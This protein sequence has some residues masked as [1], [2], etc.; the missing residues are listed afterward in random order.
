[1]AI[2]K[3]QPGQSV[4]FKASGSIT[5]GQLVTVSGDR[6]VTA[7]TAA[8]GAKAIGSAATAAANG[9]DVLVLIGGV[10]LLEAAS[11]ITAGALVVGAD[12]G[13]IAA[14]A[15]VTTPTPADVTSTRAILGI[16]LTSVD[17]S[18]A[19]D[20]RIEVLLFR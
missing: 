12:G 11:D 9:E 6:E 3:F 13:K 4:T 8:N 17:V 5:A 16:A 19:A 20:D 18:E 2:H 1:M 10:Q 15:A 7:G 14:V